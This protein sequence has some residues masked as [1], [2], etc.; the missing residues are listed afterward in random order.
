MKSFVK[1]FIKNS[2][3]VNVSLA[4]V[5]LLGVLTASRM[6]SSFFPKVEERFII[7]EATYPGASPR[8]IEEGIVLKI[9]ENLKSV[10][11]I[12]RVTSVS[13]ENSAT[14]TI[15]LNYGQN[16]DLILQDVKNAVDQISTFPADL[17]RLVTYVRE[18]ENFTAKVAIIGEVPLLTLKDRAEAFEDGLRSFPN[19]SKIQLSGF[20]Q[21][22][23][24]VAVQESKL[25][26]YNLTFEEIALA[27][28]NENIQTTGGTIKN[29]KEVIIRADQ[30][31]YAADKLRDVVVKTRPDGNVI[32]LSDVATIQEDWAESTNK[33]Y[34]NGQQAILVTV[35]TLNKENILNAAESVVEYVDTFNKQNTAVEAMLIRDGTDVL[36]ERISLLTENGILGA[37]LVMIL[38]GLF[39]RIRLAFWVAVGI[40]IS[41]LGMFVLLSYFDITIN[42]LSLFGMI[43]VIGILVDDGI[44]IG[45]N[46]F[47]HYERGKSK[48]RA[49]IDGTMEVMPSVFSA[50]TTTCLAFSFFFFIDGQLGEFFSD[51]AL[52]VICALGFSLIEVFLFLPAHLAHIKDLNE[53]VEPNKVKMYIENLLI[54][55]R[56]KV[57]APMVD[58]VL[59]YKVFAF[60]VAVGLLIITFGGFAGGIIRATFF[61][62]IEQTQVNVTLEYPSGTADYITEDKMLEIE[63]AAR[64]LDRKYQKEEGKSIISDYEVSIG[65]GSN[66]GVATFYLISSE[67]RS[68]RSFQ[69]A[70]DL[71]EEVGPVPNATQLSYETA[72]PFGKPLNVSFSGENFDRLRAAVDDFKKEVIKTDMVKDLVTNDQADQPELNIELTEAGRALGFTLRNVI[73]Q[74]RNGF[75]GYEAQ[76]LQ[77][78]DDEVKVWVRYDIE[79]R[80][81]IEDLENMRIRSPQGE[82]VP[83]G[84]IAHIKPVSG[85]IAINHLDGKRQIRLEGELASFEVSSTEMI[86]EVQANIIPL[87]SQRYP[88]VNI[89]LDGQQREI[90]KLQ[91][92]VAQVGPIILI[93]MAAMLIFTFRSLSQTV[94]LLL[95]IPFG[96]IGAGWGHFLH[97][98][99][100]SVLSF[101][102][103]IALIGVLINDGLVYIATVNGYLQ[104]GHDYDKSLK[105]TSISRFRPIFLTTITTTAGLAPLILERSFQAQFLIPMAITIAY[106]LLIGS[107]VLILILPIFLSTFNRAKVY[108]QW[109]WEGQK[110]THEEVEKAVIRQ[111][112]RKEYE[113]L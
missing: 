23:V 49:V 109:L 113:A 60:F 22:E 30:K 4:L 92:S 50:L 27:I 52:V 10:S 110:P 98:Q 1:F 87:V 20:T 77:R 97:G 26:A 100:M 101:L 39:L 2:L 38:L 47:Q 15:E 65:P 70:S 108:L 72:T 106:G 36:K 85:L 58:F 66:K 5:T 62:N 41:F 45:E 67:E 42:V 24:E 44:V 93:L 79:D 46:V 21:E 56:D 48:Y 84:E 68:L 86:S 51:V 40:P 104:E 89:M 55:Y 12:D 88:D 25:R 35:N 63:Q 71:R 8:E 59:R 19:I 90:G 91:K 3:L 103:F 78:G 13:Q 14:I 37:I 102:G 83:V 28:R 53:D 11:G 80:Q 6:N 61:P 43:L 73:G 17:E 7:V 96:I 99:P 29:D 34:Y 107:L 57:F 112:K 18:V 9:E 64:D 82:L 33:A 95:I 76:R 32:R 111:E 94:A 75:F 69:I 31:Q 105:M 16:A 54:R 81:D 74:I